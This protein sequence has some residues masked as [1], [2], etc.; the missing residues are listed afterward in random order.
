[1]PRSIPISA[2]SLMMMASEN[3]TPRE[4]VALTGCWE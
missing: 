1:L 2:D 3:K 4:S